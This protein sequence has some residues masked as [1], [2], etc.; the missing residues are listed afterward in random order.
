[1]KYSK[2]L[3]NL[4]ILSFGSLLG[5]ILGFLCQVILARNLTPTALG[6]YSAIFFLITTIAPLCGFGISQYWLKIFGQHGWQGMSWVPLSLKFINISTL[7]ILVFLIFWGALI[8]RS[9]S[10]KLT[11]MIMSFII[12]GQLAIELTSAILQLEEKYNQLAIWQLLQPL[13]RFIF[14]FIINY[15]MNIPFNLPIIATVYVSV[16][17]IIGTIGGIKV[18]QFKKG[19]FNLQGHKKTKKERE[20]NISVKTIMK[21]AAPYGFSGLFYLIYFQLSIVLVKYLISPDAAGYYNIAF[22]F[23][24][25]A[26]ILPNVIYQKFLLPKLHR[27]AYHDKHLFYQSFIKGNYI[28]G[29]LGIIVMLTIWFLT[30]HLIPLF[31]GIEYY[32]AVKITQF[33]SINIPIVYIASSAGSILLTQNNMIH[34]VKYMG[35]SALLS[36]ILNLILIPHLGITGAIITNIICNSFLLIIYFIK[37]KNIFS[38]D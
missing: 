7:S 5:A 8:E 30:P 28:M 29:G 11:A 12:F 25:A 4:F 37:I 20:F 32:S 27:W 21:G 23:I 22:V 1:M 16:A 18:N 19:N 10:L 35:L 34:K 6:N 14:L 24:S 13:L 17:L 38:Y 3:F 33:L 26:M 9:I 36:L 2:S 31:F 15:I